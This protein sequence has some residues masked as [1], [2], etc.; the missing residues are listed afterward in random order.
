MAQAR[1]L[2]HASAPPPAPAGA[3]AAALAE[4]HP[5]AA[6]AGCLPPT[7][8]LSKPSTACPE[9]DLVPARF[10]DMDSTALHGHG[11][12]QAGRAPRGESDL[13]MPASG[14]A[15]WYATRGI[16]RS[17]RGQTRGNETQICSFLHVFICSLFTHLLMHSFNYSLLDPVFEE[18]GLLRFHY[19]AKRLCRSRYKPITIQYGK[20]CNSKILWQH[21]RGRHSIFLLHNY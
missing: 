8:P 17:E 1:C 4:G 15:C 3:P 18:I 9:L 2:Q 21:S 5:Q 12:E 19:L 10:W 7:A 11:T 13:R 16:Y 6:T 20:C 14:L